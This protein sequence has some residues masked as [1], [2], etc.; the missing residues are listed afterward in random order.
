LAPK[1]LWIEVGI[2]NQ[3]SNQTVFQSDWHSYLATIVAALPTIQIAA[4]SIFSRVENY[5]DTVNNTEIDQLDAIIK[6]EVEGVGG[7]YVDVRAVQQAWEAA[8]NTPPP[9]VASG[10]LTDDGV[11]PKTS[12]VAMISTAVLSAT[13]ITP[14]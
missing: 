4:V 6:T 2:N 1:F 11:H 13:T 3:G 9:G 10:L 12:G 8:N 7:T 14:P 5:P